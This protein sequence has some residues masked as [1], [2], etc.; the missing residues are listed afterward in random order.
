MS[1]DRHAEEQRKAASTHG[2]I[3]RSKT[4]K[5]S[6]K[7]LRVILVNIMIISSIG[8]KNKD[9]TMVSVRCRV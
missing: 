7:Q 9:A 5:S 8:N 6:E 1:I 4:K 2:A 3:R